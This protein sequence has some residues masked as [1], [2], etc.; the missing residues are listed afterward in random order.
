METNL[1]TDLA[2]RILDK[3]LLRKSVAAIQTR[4]GLSHDPTVTGERAQAVTL[5][6][7][8]RPED[9]VLSSEIL[10]SRQEERD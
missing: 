3:Q 4:L 10:R 1:T 9:R 2:G 5:A 7:G 8:I 6:S